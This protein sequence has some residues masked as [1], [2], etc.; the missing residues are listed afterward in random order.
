MGRVCTIAGSVLI[1]LGLTIAVGSAVMIARDDAYRRAELEYR[2]NVGSA[3]AEVYE[4]KLGGAQVRRAFQGVGVVVGVLLSL[5]G[6][7]LLGLGVVANRS[8]NLSR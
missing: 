8:T 2:H 6:V 3:M 1:F 4:L 5:N 7:T